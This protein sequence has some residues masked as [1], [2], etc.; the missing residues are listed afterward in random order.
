VANLIVGLKEPG[1]LGVP[2]MV[3]LWFALG[4]LLALRRLKLQAP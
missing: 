2:Y 1:T 3:Y 4:V